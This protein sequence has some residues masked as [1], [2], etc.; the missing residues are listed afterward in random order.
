MGAESR[1]GGQ[2]QT[3]RGT[4]SQAERAGGG[5]GVLQNLESQSQA[6]LCEGRA[7]EEPQGH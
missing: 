3:V 6:L 4:Q 1:K 2:V 7:T 5:E